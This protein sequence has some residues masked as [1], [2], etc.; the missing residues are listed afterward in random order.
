[1]CVEFIELI[2]MYVEV[3]N[4]IELL[5]ALFIYIFFILNKLGKVH[6]KIK[7]KKFKKCESL[8]KLYIFFFNGICI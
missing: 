1:M 2:I 5:N 7:I 8:K 6:S 3:K 4:K